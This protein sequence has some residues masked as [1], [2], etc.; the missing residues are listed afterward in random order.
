MTH[1][2][3]F[4]VCK[5]QPSSDHQAKIYIFSQARF[6]YKKPAIYRHGHVKG[7]TIINMENKFNLN[8]HKISALKDEKKYGANKSSFYTNTP[9]TIFLPDTHFEMAATT[10]IP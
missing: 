1:F 6:H 8:H 3:H 10:I 2:T 4:L 5:N 7:H 9:S